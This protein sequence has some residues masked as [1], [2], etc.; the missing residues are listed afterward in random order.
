M[1]QVSG[2]SWR[3]GDAAKTVKVTEAGTSV[4]FGDAA[5]QDKWLSGS[6]DAVRNRKG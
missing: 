5:V 3:Y 1:E 6:S 2:W 4:T